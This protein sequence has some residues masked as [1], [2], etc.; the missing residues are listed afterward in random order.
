MSANKSSSLGINVPG[1][2]ADGIN[3]DY[4]VV[5]IWIN[6]KEDLTVVS[7]ATAFWQRDFD[8]RDP[9]HEMD[10]VPLYVAELKN[11]STIPPGTASLLA[12]TWAGAGQGLTNSD[13]STILARDPFA[14]GSSTID[15]TRFDLAI[16]QTLP[17]TPPPCGGQPLGYTA[18]LS[19]STTT[20]QGKSATDAFSIGFTK[21]S[22]VS[23]GN[24]FS[25]N[26][27]N[28]QTLGW[29]NTWGHDVSHGSGSEAT[30]TVTGPSDCTY[31]GPTDVQVYKDNVYGT[32]MFAWVN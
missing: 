25:A 32:F 18:T 31:G 22:G 30:A 16:G 20:T 1:P 13:Y 24:W 2:I 8:S 10:V 19:T 28:T 23:F 3:H 15:S 6:P 29:S 11:P 12:R 14:S 4:D 26:F 9:A 21:T 27:T 7:S 5:L 17:Y